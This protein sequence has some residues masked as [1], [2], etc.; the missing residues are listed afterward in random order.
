MTF[1]KGVFYCLIF[2]VLSVFS[3]EQ[4]NVMS[5]NVGYDEALYNDGDPKENYW[6]NRRSL[7]VGL[8]S[9]HEPDI[10]GMQ[11]PHLH[12]VKYFEENLEKYDWVG[13]GREDGKE[14]GEYIPIFYN[15][16]KFELLKS[17]VFWLSETPNK[18]SKSWDA[19]YT[20]ICTWALFEVKETKKKFYVFNTHFDSKGEEARLYSSKL[21][22]DRISKIAQGAPVFLLGDFNFIPDSKA[23]KEV[24]NSGLK[25]SKFIVQ[26]KPYGPQ[27]TF[28][29]FRFNNVPKHRIDYIFVNDTIDVLKHGTLTDSY[30]MKYPSDHFP[31]W[32]TAK[33]KTSN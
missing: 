19:G 24:L 17:D 3:Q 29:G 16:E 5:Y 26:S 33:F 7:Q 15:V 10:I 18:V 25:D 21:V 12:Q 1:F 8:I 2:S 9:F 30:E 32:I 23:Y 4:I 14:E 22:K 20:R 31:I 11:E 13:Y 28:N 6:V 27:G